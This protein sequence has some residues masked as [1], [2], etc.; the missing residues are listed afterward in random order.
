[1]AGEGEA[2]VVPAIGRRIELFPGLAPVG[3]EQDAVSRRCRERS[4]RFSAHCKAARAAGQN[5]GPRGT[6]I[7]RSENTALAW[8]GAR[9]VSHDTD[10]ISPGNG[11]IGLDGIDASVM[12]KLDRL[13]GVAR[14]VI[15][16]DAVARRARREQ[17]AVRAHRQLPAA[18]PDAVGENVAI[19]GKSLAKWRP[20]FAAVRALENASGCIEPSRGRNE[21]ALR[22]VWIDDDRIAGI[23]PSRQAVFAVSKPTR[24][25]GVVRRRIDPVGIPALA[26]R[27]INLGGPFW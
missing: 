18:P 20:V 2:V 25:L 3:A 5:L 16:K 17:G 9:V 4:V 23:T 6:E 11:R 10:V 12:G 13:P 27:G 26:A 24:R 14:C 21:N 19:G 22:I 8:I 1:M 7:V 15:A